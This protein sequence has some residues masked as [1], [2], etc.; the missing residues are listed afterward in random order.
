MDSTK[1]LLVHLAKKEHHL[2]TPL[3]DEV[4]LEKQLLCL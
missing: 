1:W 2:V 4:P 3:Y